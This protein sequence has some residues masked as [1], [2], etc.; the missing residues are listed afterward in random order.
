MLL[1]KDKPWFLIKT[2]QKEGYETL[3]IHYPAA[4]GNEINPGHMYAQNSDLINY[5]NYEKA[6]SDVE[7]TIDKTLQKK[8][9]FLVYFCNE[10]SHLSYKKSNR[11]LG[12]WISYN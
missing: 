7:I 4:L 10:V 5:S 9:N 6:L 11:T 2:L 1:I 3:G 12:I 8:G